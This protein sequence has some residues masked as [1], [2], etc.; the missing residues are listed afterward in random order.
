MTYILKGDKM[1]NFLFYD[2]ETGE[3]FIVETENKE[4]AYTCAYIFFK[5]PK[6]I[7]EITE[8]EAD[9]LG[10]DTY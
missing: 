3:H 9:A 4:K 8:W 6:L 7:Q 1:R 2:R 10:Y 5:K